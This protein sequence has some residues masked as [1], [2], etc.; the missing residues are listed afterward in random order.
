VSGATSV[1][2]PTSGT[3]A[4]LGGGTYTGQIVGRTG[5]TGAG[6]APIKLVSGSLNTS[7][8]VGALEFLTDALYFVKTTSTTRMSIPFGPSAGPITFAGPTAARTYTLPDA[9][10]TLART[11]GT[12][13]FTSLQTFEAATGIDIAGTN[14]TNSSLKIG[15]FEIQPYALNN[16]WF[17]EN[18]YF[19][20]SNFKNRATGTSGMFYFAAD[21]LAIR[22]YA[23]S[24]A[25]TSQTQQSTA[26]I[27]PAGAGFGP[28][29]S[30]SNG[31]FS[32]SKL[33]IRYSD[34]NVGIGTQTW[35]T[36]AVSVLGIVNGTAPTTSP[37]GM[38]QLYVESGALKY[39][40]SSGTVTTIANP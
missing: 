20:G 13:S 3:L 18:I 15:T 31:V 39:R 30:A 10:A 23:S 7:P 26:K 9:N 14:T 19:D 5:G 27:S 4:T 2:L 22:T 8:E 40:G 1:T 34:G 21:E 11:N 35:G 12:N 25:G 28:T 36:S 17:G 33:F 37:A 16:S 32:G 29:I 38:G 24:S 6:T